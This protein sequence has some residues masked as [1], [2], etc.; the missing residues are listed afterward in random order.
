MATKEVSAADV[1]K[2][3]R[4]LT[5]AEKTNLGIEV[6]VPVAYG[7]GEL[8]SVVV[9]QSRSG[10]LVHDAGFSAMRLTSTG[11]SLTTTI[12]R[13][14]AEVARRYRCGFT[15]GRVFAHAGTDDIAQAVCLVANAAR[16]VADY[17]YEIRR[18]A[19]TDFRLL[20][21][22]KLREI[23]GERAHEADE[24]RGKSGRLYRIPFVLNANMTGPQNFVSTV[25]NR[26]A[27]PLSFATLSDLR[28][29]YP[30]VERDAVYDDEA[31]L[32]DEDRTFLR[33]ADAEVFG[34]MEA[35]LRF[36]AFTHTVQ[37]LN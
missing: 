24:F 37:K 7:D 27:V 19:E 31:G 25:A 8:V 36:R 22:E 17:V 1:E 30:M 14:L 15:E 23:V 34:W 26:N 3:I 16:S 2:A 35:E 20:V 4:N 12:V 18:Q 32:R 9:E 11:V 29:A 13:R 6:T 33:S 28:G 5:V 10:L 21:V